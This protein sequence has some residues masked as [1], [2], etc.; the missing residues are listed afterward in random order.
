MRATRGKIQ[1]IF[2]N[3]INNAFA[4]LDDGGRFRVEA[5][6][7]GKDAVSIVFIDYGRGI[8]GEDLDHVFDPFFSTRKDQG[9]T[10]LGLSITYNL[11]HELGGTI[12]VTSDPETG[13]RFT[14]ILPLKM[15]A[16]KEDAHES[17]V[18][19]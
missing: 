17:A 14:V 7:K 6:M 5:G 10:G 13:T 12:G 4:A 3:I 19:G 15:R 1:Q 2:L 8:S 18:G 11:V 16:G 9:G